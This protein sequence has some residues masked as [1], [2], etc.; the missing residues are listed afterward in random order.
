MPVELTIVESVTELETTV[1]EVILESATTPGP[2]GPGVAAGGDE[3]QVLAKASD[4]DYDTEWVDMSGGP[5]GGA[6]TD[7]TYLVTTAN[8]DLDAEVVVGATPGG[9]LGGTWASP[10]VDATH[11]GSSHASVQAAAEATAAGALSAHEADTTGI[12]GIA[13][14]SALLDTGDIGSTVQPNDSDLTA[15]AALTTTSFGRGLLEL[16]NSAALLSAA[17]AQ[18]SDAD[19]TAI[20]GLTPTNDDVVQRKAGAWT[21]RSMAQ[22]I[23]DLA[24]L[25]TTFQP[26]DSDLT[27][28]AALTTTSFG[29]GLLA[30]A[31]AASVRATLDLEA[32]T[33]FPS[34]STFNDHSARHESGGSDAIK[35]DDLAAPDDNTDLNVSTSLHGLAPKITGSDGDVLTKSGSSAV[36]STPSGGA[37]DPI[38]DVFGT[39]TAASYEF[40]GSD[41]AGMTALRTADVLD[42]DSIIPGHLYIRDDGSGWVGAYDGAFSTPYTAIAFLADVRGS[43]NDGRKA[44]IFYA[45]ASPGNMDLLILGNGSRQI[46]AEHSDQPDGTGSGNITAS[47]I[48]NVEPPIYLALRLNS[49]TDVD[50]LYS[51]NGYVWRKLVDSRNPVSAESFGSVSAVGLAISGSAGLHSAAFGFLRVWSSALS[52][53]G[54]LA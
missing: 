4:D 11:S 54:E 36:W 8:G 17:G 5:G 40:N 3:G 46:W 48:S 51:H 7:A 52:F 15:I 34:L 26:L 42:E 29:R 23:A 24:A 49:G 41:L 35:L 39:P 6:P 13:D 20:A 53:P 22:L 37:P 32:G 33:D 14:T 27:A 38:F 1:T 18:A 12:H 16:A 44:G 30:E 31:S 28:I 25:G 2:A 19:L 10:T 9:E 45:E 47:D 43:Q 50:F 21:N